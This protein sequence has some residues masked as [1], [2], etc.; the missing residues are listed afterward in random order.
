MVRQPRR[1]HC[2]LILSQ[3]DGTTLI[4]WTLNIVECAFPTM[5][6][7]ILWNVNLIA[8]KESFEK[9]YT[10]ILPEQVRKWK[11]NPKNKKKP[12]LSLHSSLL[13]WFPHLFDLCVLPAGFGGPF[14]QPWCNGAVRSRS[15]CL[16]HRDLETGVFKSSWN[17]E[18]ETSLRPNAP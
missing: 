8:S 9:N 17:L 14:P 1:T 15:N 2:G 4:L 7:F 5:N 10:L 18:K 12:F 11:K 3:A 13:S 16:T 6:C